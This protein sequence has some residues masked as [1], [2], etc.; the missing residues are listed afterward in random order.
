MVPRT[1]AW[2]NRPVDLGEGYDAATYGDHV[3]DIYDLLYGPDEAAVACLQG[4]AG[5][6][7]VLEL[8]IGTGRLALPLAAAGL[9]VQGIDASTAMVERLRAKPGGDAIAV[10]IGDLADVAVAGEFSLV[11]VAFNTFFVLLTPEDQ[12]RCFANVA[13][14][15][16]PGGR[17]VIEA[18]VPDPSRFVRGQHVEIAH[19]GSDGIR[20]N[21]SRHDAAA[22]RVAS[23]VLWVSEDRLRAWPVQLRYAFP[24]ELD[25]MAAN[26]GLRLEHR[27]STWEG[28]PFAADSAAHVSVYL[29][30]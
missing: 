2:S 14:R 5:R 11:F 1:E 27:W 30:A 9:E 19:L 23:L 16:A 22:Q 29:R 20:V 17:F 3:A 24:A 26:A 13:R 28:E 12:A 6:G 10:T 8:A 18:F 4:L 21:V 7:P 15:L 25:A